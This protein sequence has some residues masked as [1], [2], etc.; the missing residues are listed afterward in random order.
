MGTAFGLINTVVR[1]PPVPR[2]LA[3]ITSRAQRV[4]EFDRRLMQVAMESYMRH[5]VEIDM[6]VAAANTGC[7]APKPSSS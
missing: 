7:H 5:P 4:E 3:A 1:P 2:G 6:P